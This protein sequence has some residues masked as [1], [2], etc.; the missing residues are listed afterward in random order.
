ME[1]GIGDTGSRGYRAIE[2]RDV[3][4]GI[5]LP[6]RGRHMA[7]QNYRG[8]DVWQRGMDLIDEA[9]DVSELF[10]SSERF[11]MASQL[12]RASLSVPT[13]IAEGHGRSHRGDY[14]RFLS[15]ARGSVCEVET[16]L[17][18]AVRREYVTQER[19]AVAWDL[20]QRVG[21]MLLRL[22]ESLQRTRDR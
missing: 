9:Y 16:L 14:L 10:P 12:Q 19:I 21:Q 18:A 8:L 4:T 17:L 13:N 11:G 2:D 15:I 5:G 7:I 22:I 1:S 6:W 20:C 3:G